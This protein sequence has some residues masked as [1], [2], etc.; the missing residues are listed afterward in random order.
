[1]FKLF[2]SLIHHVLTAVPCYFRSPT[3]LQNVGKA[4]YRL[5]VDTDNVAG[6]FLPI[7]KPIH[8]GSKRKLFRDIFGMIYMFNYLRYISF[9][10]AR[11]CWFVARR[12]A[13]QGV[14]RAVHEDPRGRGGARISAGNCSH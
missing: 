9:L 8:E 2:L 13:D 10:S 7:Y 5:R 11:V 1:M 3:V 14:P 4:N 12:S 6:V